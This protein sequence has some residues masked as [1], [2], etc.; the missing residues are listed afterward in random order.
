M[1]KNKNNLSAQ[2][3]TELKS[4]IFPTE[5]SQNTDEERTSD[6]ECASDSGSSLSHTD[7][8]VMHSANVQDSQD[9]SC[10]DCEECCQAEVIIH[11]SV[12]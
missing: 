8:L 5:V 4:I 10:P 11:S 12:F 9:S 7:L 1:P 6:D 2:K 3:F